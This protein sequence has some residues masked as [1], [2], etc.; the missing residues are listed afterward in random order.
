M[1]KFTLNA[2]YYI[3]GFFARVISKKYNEVKHILSTNEHIGLCREESIF[4]YFKQYEKINEGLTTPTQE[5]FNCIKYMNNLVDEVFVRNLSKKGI[6]KQLIELCLKETDFTFLSQYSD[7][8]NEI[9]IKFVMFKIRTTLKFLN[10]HLA[11]KLSEKTRTIQV[12]K[13]VTH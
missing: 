8:K 11:E 3:A 7:L 12:L 5:F 2:L 1:D 13:F 6:K 9:V 4:T 10:R